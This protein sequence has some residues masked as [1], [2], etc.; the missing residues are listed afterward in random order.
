M[1]RPREHGPETRELLLTIAARV[2]NDEGVGA[3]SVRRLGA[4]ADV[5]ARA[6][7]SLFGD[8]RGLLA[9]LFRRGCETMVHLHEQ[10]PINADPIAEIGQL[11]LA[12]RRGALEQR[13]LY[14]LMFERAAPGFRPDEADIVFAMRSL[15]RVHQAVTRAIGRRRR[16]DPEVISRQLWALVHGLASLELRGYLAAPAEAEQVWRNAISALSHG[17]LEPQTARQPNTKH[18]PAVRPSAPSV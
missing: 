3:L 15:D 13:E 14:G 6:V 1:G 12:Y 4:E 10:V 8:M 11:A 5:S 17:L 9:E 7:Y 16:L 2:L 18:L